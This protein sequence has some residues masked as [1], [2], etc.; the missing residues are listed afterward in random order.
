MRPY[1]G[2]ARGAGRTTWMI[3]EMVDEVEN[4]QPMCLVY[5]HNFAFACM[6]LTAKTEQEL[7]R[8]RIPFRRVSKNEIECMGSRIVFLSYAN[9][10][11]KRKQKE[12]KA[13][14][15]VDHYAIELEDEKSFADKQYIK[16]L[17]K[18]IKAEW[19]IK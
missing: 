19:K 14:V 6:Y 2:G 9:E 1:P 15:F 7:A 11:D 5:A 10:N 4:G 18:E 16:G 12:Y 8:R 13:S 3:Q 17:K